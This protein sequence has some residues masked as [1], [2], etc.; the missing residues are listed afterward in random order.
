MAGLGIFFAQGYE[1][2]EALIVV[3]IVRR[4]G[5]PIRTISISDEKTVVSSHQVPVVTD[6]TLKEVDFDALDMM[7]L[8]G[9]MPGTKNLEA[10]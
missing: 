3:D 9:G 5:L 10:C 7:I 8:P 1:E 2:C 4:A 6:C